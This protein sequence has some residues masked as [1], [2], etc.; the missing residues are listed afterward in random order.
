MND[1]AEW[2]P[3]AQPIAQAFVAAGMG[4]ARAACDE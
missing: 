2:M 1:L 3:A 4:Y